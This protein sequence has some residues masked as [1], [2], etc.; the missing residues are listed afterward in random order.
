G[1]VRL[2]EATARAAVAE[3][4]SEEVVVR[5]LKLIIAITRLQTII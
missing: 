4:G 3:A 2:R 1:S 5:Q